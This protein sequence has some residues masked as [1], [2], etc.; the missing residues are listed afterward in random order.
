MKISGSLYDI[1]SIGGTLKRVKMNNTT[2][3]N[4]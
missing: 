1:D 4:L 2:K 3:L